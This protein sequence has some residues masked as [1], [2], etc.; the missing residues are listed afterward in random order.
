VWQ[1]LVAGVVVAIAL[2]LGPFALHGLVEAFHL[3]V[4]PWRV[5]RGHDVTD[6]A[7]RE[8]VTQGAVVGIAPRAVGHHAPGGDAAV[9][10]PG[11]GAL[12]EGGDGGGPLVI[13]QLAIGQSAVVVDDGVEVVVAQRVAPLGAGLV[14]VAG[15][16]VSGAREARVALDVHVQQV[17]R[18]RPLVAT[19]RRPR[20]LGAAR[21]AVAAQH[22]V[23][24]GVRNS[25]LAGDQ[26]RTPPGPPALLADAPFGDR[27]GA[28]RRPARPAGTVERPPARPAVLLAGL[29]PAPLPPVRRAARDR[30]GRGRGPLARALLN[31]QPNQ[32]DPA[33]RSELAPK[34]LTHPGPPS[35]W[36]I[37]Q[38]HSLRS[39]PDVF[40]AAH[41]L[42]GLLN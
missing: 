32:L 41:D 34:V 5:G 23:H 36:I 31:H 42:P 9:G 12:S 35:L 1:C 20:R 33:G 27:V 24:G 10:K 2:A 37:R 8:Q 38:T 25:D 39:G 19:E 7:L 26:P 16:R 40:S 21:Q 11:Q 4:P 28:R 17:A 13:E 14:P 6:V 18:A 30:E 3:A 22:R 15:D 29:K